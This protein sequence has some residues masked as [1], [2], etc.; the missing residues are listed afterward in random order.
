MCPTGVGQVRTETVLLQI[1]HHSRRLRVYLAEIA[2]RELSP[3]QQEELA[4]HLE[5]IRALAEQKVSP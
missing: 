1:E 4:G 3:E 5:T 2:T